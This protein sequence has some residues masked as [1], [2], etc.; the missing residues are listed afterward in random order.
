MNFIKLL[1]IFTLLG[2]LLASCSI[3]QQV[4]FNKDFSGTT[5]ISVQMGNMMNMAKSLSKDSTE[6]R[7]FDFEK[8]VKELESL[9][10]ISNVKFKKDNEGNVMVSYDFAD[11]ETLNKTFGR[12]SI[13]APENDPDFKAFEVRGKKLTYH[14]PKSYGMDVAEKEGNMDMLKNMLDYKLIFSFDRKIRKVD[15]K[16]ATISEDKKS[17]TIEGNMDEMMSK[18]VDLGMTVKLR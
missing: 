10:G 18:S 17:L 12:T 13:N 2:L 3:Q 5:T 1:G 7:S 4:H 14:A 15:N 8:D 9:T 6:G 11:I 16:S